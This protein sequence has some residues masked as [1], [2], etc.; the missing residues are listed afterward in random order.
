MHVHQAVERTSAWVVTGGTDTGVMKLVGEAMHKYGLVDVPV[1]GVAPWGAISA[2]KSLAPEDRPEP[3][4][5]ADSCYPLGTIHPA[6]VTR[7]W[8]ST[9]D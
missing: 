9:W 7:Q 4:D 5:T 1:V 6:R 3:V 8:C 2:R